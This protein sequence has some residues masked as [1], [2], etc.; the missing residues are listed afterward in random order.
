MADNPGS[1]TYHDRPPPHGMAGAVMYG[2][3]LNA[4]RC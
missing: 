1:R 4:G 3:D 2:P